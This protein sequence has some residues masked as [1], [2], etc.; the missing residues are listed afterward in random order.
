RRRQARD[1]SD[2]SLPSVRGAATGRARR[3]ALTLFLHACYSLAHSRGA[4]AQLGERE[5][6]SL[7]VGGSIP[8]RSTTVSLLPE[9]L[10]LVLGRLGALVFVA[11]VR[12]AGEG[13]ADA[14]RCLGAGA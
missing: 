10:L 13:E 12:L 5:A 3:R 4:L 8:P 11:L 1:V 7:E 6:G 2:S 14:G 9:D